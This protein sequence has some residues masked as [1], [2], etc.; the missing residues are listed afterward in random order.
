MN[1]KALSPV[2]SAIIVIAIFLIGMVIAFGFFVNYVRVDRTSP[3][4]VE[5]ASNI[6][7]TVPN[8]GVL[9]DNNTFS[10][11]VMNNSNETQKIMI[12]F[13]TE[14]NEIFGAN[15]SISE[16][17]DS[18]STISQEL[19]YPGVWTIEVFSEAGQIIKTYSFTVEPSKAAADVQ[20]NQFND[21]Q[22]SKSMAF[23]SLLTGVAGVVLGVL[24][25]IISY[26]AYRY[27]RKKQESYE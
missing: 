17:S 8:Y 3:L 13:H 4:S 11:H 25:L 22:Y 12:I 24:A 19:F 6:Y 16:K 18:D 7:S 23:G 27:S 10:F 21:I 2:L 15:F 9:G 26:L 20:I 1:K 14:Q 5:I